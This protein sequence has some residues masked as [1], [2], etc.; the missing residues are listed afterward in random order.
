[1]KNIKLKSMI[2]FVITAIILYILLKDNFFL[3]LSEI[4]NIN[5]V[6]FVI[7]CLLFVFYFLID[8]TVLFIL[9]R[10]Y[11][12]DIKISSILKLGIET[13]FF[14][15]ITPLAS[16]GQPWQ[17]YRLGKYNINYVDGTSI[18][19]QNF[20]LFQIA[21]LI[22]TSLCLIVFHFFGV[23]S[24]SFLY[25]ITILGFLINLLV[26]SFLFLIGFGKKI[27]YKV[28]SF[29]IKIFTK[30]RLVKDYETTL[31]NWKI[32]C[33]NYRNNT[34]YLFKNKKVL[35]IGIILYLISTSIYYLI[36][37]FVFL[38]FG[39]NN[40]SF[41]DVFIANSLIFIAGCFIPIPG[42]SGGMEYAYLEYFTPL[43]SNQTILY[44]T[45]IIWR[46]ITFYLPTFIGGIYF[47]FRKR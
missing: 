44:S 10:M 33:Q 7:A 16:G 9:T 30:L 12:K 15:G 41:V 28:I 8:N 39:V 31:N 3:I 32:K 6:F 29:F 46:F 1:M 27:N 23:L 2:I 25:F 19:S 20:L 36:P 42:A 24:N 45:L 22:I 26:L 43:L 17:V 18:V 35:I 47:C 5:I 4:T 14:N 11:N 34:I 13:K 21:M 37:Y 40:I 38:S